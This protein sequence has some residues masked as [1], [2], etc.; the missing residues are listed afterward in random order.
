MADPLLQE[1]VQEPSAPV[2]VI[3]LDQVEE[4]FRQDGEEVPPV[5]VLVE[6]AKAKGY[7]K[8]R[9]GG[10]DFDF[11]SPLEQEIPAAPEPMVQAEP[12][13]LPKTIEADLDAAR[14]RR[15][16]K[17]FVRERGVLDLPPAQGDAFL[18]YLAA[19]VGE[20]GYER[21]PALEAILGL[22]D[23]DR[24]KVG[25]LIKD[26]SIFEEEQNYPL[27]PRLG[28]PFAGVSADERARNL[29]GMAAVRPDDPA[30]A[31]VDWAA[32]A[33]GGEAKGLLAVA[34]N[35]ARQWELERTLGTVMGAT[36]QPEGLSTIYHLLQSEQA[37][38]DPSMVGIARMLVESR[39]SAAGIDFEPVTEIPQVTVTEA[40]V[41]SKTRPSTG[42]T[43]RRK[44]E[45]AALD[46][47]LASTRE[48][49]RDT[50]RAEL[51]PEAAD[52]AIEIQGQEEALIRAY[53]EVFA[54]ID[55]TKLGLK[56]DRFDLTKVKNLEVLIETMARRNGEGNPMTRPELEGQVHA[57]NFVLDALAWTSRRMGDAVEAFTGDY[58]PV[59]YVHPDGAIFQDPI[60]SGSYALAQWRA[61]P[62]AYEWVEDPRLQGQ[63]PASLYVRGAN[64][65]ASGPTTGKKP[66]KPT[67][68]EINAEDFAGWA[69]YDK[70]R[71][72]ED[73]LFSQAIAERMTRGAPPDATMTHAVAGVLSFGTEFLDPLFLIGGGS[74]KYAQVVKREKQVLQALDKA[75]VPVPAPLKAPGQILA[76]A[77]KPLAVQSAKQ[78]AG[79]TQRVILP[80]G[81]E[82]APALVPNYMAIKDMLGG[83][84]ELAKSVTL[85]IKNDP[86]FFTKGLDALLADP[87]ARTR[88]HQAFVSAGVN[89]PTPEIAAAMLKDAAPT[90]GFVMSETKAM[91]ALDKAQL[92]YRGILLGRA[93]MYEKARGL[94]LARLPLTPV[95][96]QP[97]AAMM[98]PLA[99][100]PIRKFR[101]W[102]NNNPG[103][104][105]KVKSTLARIMDSQA[106]IRSAVH[107]DTRKLR[108]PELNTATGGE[109]VP[110]SLGLYRLP[111]EMSEH[112]ARLRQN[113]MAYATQVDD[114]VADVVTAHGMLPVAS[115]EYTRLAPFLLEMPA[116]TVLSLEV[117]RTVAGHRAMLHRIEEIHALPT[118][119]ARMDK[120]AEILN[121]VPDAEAERVL[122]VLRTHSAQTDAARGFY[123]SIGEKDAAMG[124]LTA[125]ADYVNHAYY[126]VHGKGELFDLRQTDAGGVVNRQRI[127]ESKVALSGHTLSRDLD[128]LFDAMVAGFVPET[129]LMILLHTRASAHLADTN[130]AKTIMAVS[131]EFG[132]L[133]PTQAG[134]MNI[135]SD[136][137]PGY[138][139]VGYTKMVQ[140][141]TA[142]ADALKVKMDEAAALVKAERRAANRVERI[143]AK[144]EKVPKSVQLEAQAARAA[145][146]Q[147]VAEIAREYH[148]NADYLR[149][150]AQHTK[151]GY[152]AVRVR[153]FNARKRLKVDPTDAAARAELNTL[154]DQWG[155]YQGLR[156]E[157][158]AAG[159][160]DGEAAALTME[161]YG[162]PTLAHLDPG[163]GSALLNR[164]VKAK[165]AVAQTE[166]GERFLVSDLTDAAKLYADTRK[167]NTYYARFVKEDE[168]AIAG[169]LSKVYLPVEQILA[170]RSYGL[171]ERGMATVDAGA[172]A[173]ISRTW[174]KWVV[175]PW[176][177][178][179]TFW[180]PSI[181][182][183]RRNQLDAMNKAFTYAGLSAASP[184]VW[185]E[186]NAWR[187]GD[188]EAFVT[189]TGQIVNAQ[190]AW[191]AAKPLMQS[192]AGRIDAM[193][194][195]SM[196]SGAPKQTG[197]ALGKKIRDRVTRYAAARD[198]KR[199]WFSYQNPLSSTP[200][201]GRKM[202]GM[203][204]AF[205]VG[206]ASSEITD[207]T[208]RLWTYFVELKAGRAPNEAIQNAMVL[209]RDWSN[210]TPLQQ[211]VTA[212]LPFTFV[213]F[214]KQNTKALIETLKRGDAGRIAAWPK[215]KLMM[216]QDMPE[217]LRPEWS[218]M[219]DN[220]MGG[221]GS[222]NLP[223]DL[224]SVEFL[225]PA[226]TIT[227]AVTDA[228]GISKGP[229][230]K[231]RTR[232]AGEQLTDLFP[233]AVQALMGKDQH[234]IKLPPDLEAMIFEGLDD[235]DTEALGGLV[236]VYTSAGRPRVEL[237]QPARTLVGVYGLNI[238]ANSLVRHYDAFRHGDW[239]RWLVEEGGFAKY[240]PH[241]IQ[242]QAKRSGNYVDALNQQLLDAFWFFSDGGPGGMQ[243]RDFLDMNPD[244]RAFAEAV[245]QGNENLRAALTNLNA[246]LNQQS[247]RQGG[248]YPE[249][250]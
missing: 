83:S 146:E 10:Q 210:M 59:L 37:K 54:A 241:Q 222:W 6:K 112:L 236:R 248:I 192:V 135:L 200:T 84:E 29:A 187:A 35:A 77:E 52:L 165:Q 156:H 250:N 88:I 240:Y 108:A 228:M 49:T 91:S 190:D 170:L 9:K 142:K 3:D 207:N 164:M 181:S 71:A 223:M 85:G 115:E 149:N 60:E 239:K 92:G 218:N 56:S 117:A 69:A 47:L 194:I 220:I 184:A 126:R 141:A 18:G 152:E 106:L 99:V 17:A 233:P 63:A 172:L 245:L 98:N 215:L 120:A 209:A 87:L 151:Q 93:A 216:E 22:P 58:Q 178:L 175:R 48:L 158:Q 242:Q 163:D 131:Q 103:R 46:K 1:P 173:A 191:A 203:E 168:R 148:L 105:S 55:P 188:I 249:N 21:G 154:E 64:A 227:A 65:L 232:A 212:G 76:E 109:I 74:L 246:L 24:A 125:R 171:G 186:F 206:P 42:L 90:L 202:S 8:F 2:G 19:S 124:L 247:P 122:G 230:A 189:G 15:I 225:N 179:A 96:T 44:S 13:S 226:L 114:M 100:S 86:A 118:I 224:S 237:T 144:G 197:E 134:V 51:G 244:E 33:A 34:D 32:A 214:Y 14:R 97:I 38:A 70:V 25:Q 182:F 4:M 136:V 62:E 174:G 229:G 50:L 183:G 138:S 234:K 238:L 243:I 153:I 199:M 66:L 110:A 80:D 150:L 104:V 16:G 159:I 31:I 43:N 78:A 73:R 219:L 129:D 12:G 95:L 116:D 30:R 57:A 5:A 39:A 40:A 127:A 53:A 81:K 201:G 45:L 143:S 119:E 231:Q 27:A 75:G 204:A 137:N 167:E 61:N 28:I 23:A 176:A 185:K 36:G 221:E 101:A 79:T 72:T 121:S 196:G 208:L 139:G 180:N 111:P 155:T 102:A 89:I 140:Q 133:H 177:K 166:G 145:T 157:F 217:S 235:G 107:Y 11:A 161:L 94:Y 130:W 193:A 113:T 82:L 123:H 211:W 213:N 205:P 169:Y 128:T 41:H 195:M 7:T 132:E 68:V 160:S 67:M 198:P 147:H 20:P 162:V 26:F